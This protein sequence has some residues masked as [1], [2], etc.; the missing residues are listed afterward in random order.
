MATHGYTLKEKKRKGEK[1]S[2]CVSPDETQQ[3]HGGVSSERLQ[4]GEL[5]VG[6]KWKDL[7][8]SGLQIDTRKWTR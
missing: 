5:C 4:D 7:V 1:T 3:C 6:S 2:Q 8:L